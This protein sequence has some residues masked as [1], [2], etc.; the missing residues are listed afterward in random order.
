M[1]IKI[2]ARCR[3]RASGADRLSTLCREIPAQRF[4]RVDAGGQQTGREERIG[5]L[6]LLT[7]VLRGHGAHEI[8]ASCVRALDR[9]RVES[10]DR[11]EGIGG[12]LLMFAQPG[13][14]LRQLVEHDLD[15]VGARGGK[16]ARRQVIALVRRKPVAVGQNPHV[17]TRVD[18][19]DIRI[20]RDPCIDAAALE[21]R[22]AVGRRQVV[23]CGVGGGELC[24]CECGKQQVV[25]AGCFRDGDALALEIGERAQRA[26][27]LDDDGLRFR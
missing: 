22:A 19:C 17:G 24:A 4:T 23:D 11:G 7:E 1:A 6:L 12:L 2:I 16:A 27:A 26:V 20:P 10:P 14:G 5:D 18:R 25:A 9:L 21:R 15:D 8:A 13:A 3:F